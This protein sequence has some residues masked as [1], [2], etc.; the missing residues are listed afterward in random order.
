MN[1][2]IAKP[3]YITYKTW[4]WLIGELRTHDVLPGAIDRGYLKKRS[5]SEQ[6]GLIA[7]L[8]WFGM[9]DD[10]GAPTQLLRDYI[11]ADEIKAAA[12]F[13][14]MVEQS[15]SAVTDGSFALGS[16][17][18]N[19]LADKFREFEISGSTLTKSIS[20]FLSA[21]KDAG[22]KVSPH[23]KAPP[24]PSNGGT[25]RK[26]KTPTPLQQT[27]PRW[28]PTITR[29]ASPSRRGKEWLRSR[30]PSSG[31]RTA[32]STC[33]TRCRLSSGRTSSR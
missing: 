10:S 22:I 3:P 20:F 29:T 9:I 32:S 33:P 2:K 12:M 18:T 16:A 24:A 7:A 30:S 27:A 23:A 28:R 4:Q 31:D 6:S 1:E 11:V 13:K 14:K 21:A 17:T 26:T 8:K 15:Y 25:K 5:G 19:M